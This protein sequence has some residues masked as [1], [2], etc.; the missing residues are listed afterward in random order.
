M[1]RAP[2]VKFS[3]LERAHEFLQFVETESKVLKDKFAETSR[4]ARLSRIENVLEGRN[5]YMRFVAITGEAMG[6]NMISKGT[7]HVL[8]FLKVH[9]PDMMVISLSS[10]FCTDK[11]PS[12][13]NW[14]RG[15]GK[16]VVCEAVIKG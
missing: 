8:D 16:S 6:M 11:K 5:V 15:R 1:T 9:F 7:N 4:F 2:L 13:V 12:A 14:I 3:T 10:N